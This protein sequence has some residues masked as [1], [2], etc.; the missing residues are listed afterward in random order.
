MNSRRLLVAFTIVTL[1]YFYFRFFGFKNYS[2]A[3]IIF[4]LFIAGSMIVAI[5][6]KKRDI[7]V[8][9]LFGLIFVLFSLLFLFIF[10][11]SLLK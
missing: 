9:I 4:G 6:T 8:G 2:W 1:S 11:S 7:T 10:F 5:V 3:H